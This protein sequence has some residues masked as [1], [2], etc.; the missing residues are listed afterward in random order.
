MLS[1]FLAFR[2]YLIRKC[3]L[4]LP[5]TE[6][7]TLF[8]ATNHTLSEVIEKSNSTKN[9][10]YLEARSSVLKKKK[11]ALFVSSSQG[12]RPK[13]ESERRSS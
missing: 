9:S 6:W 1:C 11:M 7:R 8:A 3:I 12:E 10:G 2:K 5:P 13:Q 4:S